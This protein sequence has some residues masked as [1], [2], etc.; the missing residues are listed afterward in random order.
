MLLVIGGVFIGANFF[1]LTGAVCIALGA[2]WNGILFATM[3]R[4][5][6]EAA[7]AKADY[8]SRFTGQR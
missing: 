1:P 2:G 5:G 8:V 4:M 7:D 3:Q 6:R